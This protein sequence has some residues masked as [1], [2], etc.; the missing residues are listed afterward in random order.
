[1]S[2]Q[3]AKNKIEQLAEFLEDLQQNGIIKPNHSE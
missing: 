2:P 3:I 1:M